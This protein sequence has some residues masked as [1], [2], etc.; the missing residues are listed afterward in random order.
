MM[1]FNT[2][3]SICSMLAL[4][5]LLVLLPLKSMGGYLL[6][7]NFGEDGIQTTGIGNLN[8]R[9]IA[10]ALQAD[11]KIVVAGESEVGAVTKMAVIRYNADGSEDTVFNNNAGALEDDIGTFDDG[12]NSV[13]VLENGNIVVAGYSENGD[14]N[15]QIVV[16]Q[17]TAAG[18]LDISFGNG[19]VVKLEVPGV[20]GEAFDLSV[21]SQN[22]ILVGGT[23]ESGNRKWAVAAR[24]LENGSLDIDDFGDSGYRKIEIG[25][26]ENTTVSFIALQSDGKIVLGGA[27]GSSSQ[28]LAA[29]YRL[30]MDGKAMD[31]SFAADGAAF[32]DE[33][34]TESSFSEAVVLSDDSIVVAGFTTEAGRKSITTAKF[35]ATGNVDTTYGDN[36][37]SVSELDVDSVANAIVQK[38]DGSF[39]IVG[40]TQNTANDDIVLVELDENGNKQDS[41]VLTTREEVENRENN[42]SVTIS[43]LEVAEDGS[44][45]DYELIA[46]QQEAQPLLQDVGGDNDSG[47]AAI[48]TESG[49]IIVAGFTNDGNADDVAILAFA[50]DSGPE[51]LGADGT[52]GDY[53]LLIG[54]IA[55]TNV[56]R[57]SAMSGGVITQTKDYLDCD[58]DPDGENCIPGIEERGV[59][60]G[61]TAF[62]TYQESTGDTTDQSDGNQEGDTNGNSVFPS[63]VANT[64]YNSDVVRRGQTSDGSGQGTFGSDI[65]EITP[66]T[67]YYVRAYAVLSTTVSG[68]STREVIYG[69]QVSFRTNDACFIA[70]AAFGS[71]LETQVA[72]LSQ[73]RDKYLKTSKLGMKFVQAYYHYSP[74]LAER[75]SQ[76]S[77]LRFYVR[78]LLLP[79][80]GFSYFMVHFS[81]QLKIA[82]LV[83]MAG[84]VLYLRLIPS[85]RLT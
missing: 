4:L 44:L 50:S 60:Y 49:S 62:P 22:R 68:S 39:I 48:L 51:A 43:P 65:N 40:E 45:E 74:P 15:K 29:L 30:D 20:Q 71:P 18:F 41:T 25:S 54:T 28:E 72:L 5:S 69:N 23:L 31:S 42:N 7:P 70:T 66:D 76:S 36:G 8:D 1:S 16:A 19:G 14:Q 47:Q 35:T 78:L 10:A 33:S 56:Q 3:S 79:L 34:M 77:T 27:K 17:L 63:F 81:L 24:L 55:V 32:I 37:I 57:N 75:I 13:I 46:M 26:D 80:I 2:K 53:P 6:D 85:R 11:G 59:V 84:S 12:A 64:S 58:E 61:I 38:S 9:G 67:L 82:V 83:L 21:D 73:F 52:T